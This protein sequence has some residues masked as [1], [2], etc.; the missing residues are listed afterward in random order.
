MSDKKELIKLIVPI[1]IAVVII[2]FLGFS[3]FQKFRGLSDLESLIDEKNAELE[4]AESR[5]SGLVRLQENRHLFAQEQE[6]FS[7]IIPPS[8]KDREI[9]EHIKEIA[10][11]YNVY[12]EG[13]E[14]QEAVSRGFY[15]EMPVALQI[16]GSYS[17]VVHTLNEIQNGERM[18]NV[19]NTQIAKSEFGN[20]QSKAILEAFFRPITKIDVEGE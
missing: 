3:S 8:P 14:F 4:V 15:N 20:I 10:D 2:G 13:M 7:K 9:Y 17:G 11:I 5:L 12:V 1:L 19:V 6:K 18:I 16:S